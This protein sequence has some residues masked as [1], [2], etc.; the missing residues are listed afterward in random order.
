[1]TSMPP[2]IDRALELRKRQI[3]EA[4]D[5]LTAKHG[6]HSESAAVIRHR[7]EEIQA[8]VKDSQI[9]HSRQESHTGDII[10][11]MGGPQVKDAGLMFVILGVILLVAL[12]GMSTMF[13]LMMAVKW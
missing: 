7:L 12:G 11:V 9:D 3:K 10:A 5:I 8:E 2:V 13:V 4:L 6:A 1:M